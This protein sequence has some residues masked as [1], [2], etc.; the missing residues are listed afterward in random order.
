MNI[1]HEFTVP[2]PAERAW[3][4]LTDLEQ[5]ATCM[6]GAQLTGKGEEGYQGTVKVKVGPI[7][8]SYR[9]SAD[10]VTKDDDAKHA[11]ISAKGKEARGSGN[12][13]ATI[14]MRLRP[15]GED[16]TVVSVATDLSIS[17]KIAQ[18]G[19]G[20]IQEVSTK[21]LG[22]F[23]QCLESRIA[24]SGAATDEG[25]GEDAGED[26]GDG[27]GDGGDGGDGGAADGAPP[28][29]EAPAESGA[30]SGAGATQAGT[31]EATATAAP[32][33]SAAPVAAPVAAP[34]ASPAAAPRAATVT[35]AAGPEPEALNLVGVV[36]PALLK[37]LVP[38]VV[39][40]VVVVVLFRWLR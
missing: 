30:G 8:A 11:V 19:S 32:A 24:S 27:G 39:A 28:V 12:A 3:A 36:G 10:F 26:A 15:E 33:T 29:A 4:M 17:G 7:T 37:R 23:T 31:A 2:A 18:F 9:G 14:D 6:P 20:M 16:R 21:L 34:A 1:D 13:N 5:V 38:I 22:Q 40:V 35:P 25:A